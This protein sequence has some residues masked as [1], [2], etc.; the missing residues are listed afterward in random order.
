[1]R[2]ETVPQALGTPPPRRLRLPAIA[3]V[4]LGCLLGVA[5][6]SA[7]GYFWSTKSVRNN[8]IAD[9]I[10]TLERSR[11][12][13]ERTQ[14]EQVITDEIILLIQ[15]LRAAAKGNDKAAEHARLYLVS[16]AELAGK[17]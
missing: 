10:A 13:A 17:K 6:L 1:M 16:L 3:S 15:C 5:C 9:A 11:I 4:A 2:V 14:A 12:E 8:R 7:A